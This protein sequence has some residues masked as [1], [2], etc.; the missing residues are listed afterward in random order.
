PVPFTA[1]RTADSFWSSR[2]DRN[3]Q[4]TI[5]HNIAESHE[6]RRV[7]N[8][9]VA[10]HQ[11]QG[12]MTGYFFND[13]DVYK[14]LEGAAHAMATSPDPRLLDVALKNAALVLATFGPGR[15]P[16]PCGHPELELGL[17]ALYRHTHEA[18]YLDQAQWFVD[19]RGRHEGRRLFGEY[20]QDHKPVLEQDA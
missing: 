2:L 1:V 9:L 16:D 15:N 4:V 5:P 13:S 20:A 11:Q 14:V 19:A 12:G 17:L 18:K 10:A 3:R 8:F 7:A 6:T